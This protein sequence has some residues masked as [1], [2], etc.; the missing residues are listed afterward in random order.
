MLASFLRRHVT[1]VTDETRLHAINLVK[2]SM[3]SLSLPCFAMFLDVNGIMQI[4]TDCQNQVE[5]DRQTQ[6]DFLP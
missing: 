1:T 6:I 5:R 4:S 2:E 3:N